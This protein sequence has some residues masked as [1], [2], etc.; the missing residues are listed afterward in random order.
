[1]NEITTIPVQKTTR[2]KLKTF[3]VKGETYDEIVNRLME[4]TEYIIFMERQYKILSKKEEFVPLD[5][6][7]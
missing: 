3:G 5:E 4:K 7:V 6:I 2:M 1:M